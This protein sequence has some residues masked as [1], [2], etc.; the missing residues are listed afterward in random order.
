M[1]YPADKRNNQTNTSA[2]FFNALI[3]SPISSFCFWWLLVS[4]PLPPTC[5]LT[6]LLLHRHALLTPSQ[7]AGFYITP[8]GSRCV[9]SWSHTLAKYL[10]SSNKSWFLFFLFFFFF[11]GSRQIP[12]DVVYAGQKVVKGGRA[13]CNGSQVRSRMVN[14][15]VLQQLAKNT[16]ERRSFALTLG[17]QLIV[18]SYHLPNRAQTKQVS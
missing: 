2:R 14:P 9:H 5:A 11:F 8:F 16:S 13:P 12:F 7:Q 1:P 4:S 18:P 10:Y 15:L 17:I 3:R 6:G